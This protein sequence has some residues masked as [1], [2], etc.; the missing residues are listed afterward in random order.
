MSLYSFSHCRTF[1][2]I[3]TCTYM[4]YKLYFRII[5]SKFKGGCQSC[6]QQLVVW[7]RDYVCASAIYTLLH[8]LACNIASYC[9]HGLHFHLPSACA[10]ENTTPTH[11]ICTSVMNNLLTI[12][13]T[14]SCLF[15]H[16][17][18]SSSPSKPTASN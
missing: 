16:K 7:E 17:V 6:P 5:A 12:T 11:A 2:D 10:C 18:M 14:A 3:Y 15:T 1:P 9:T 13:T 8:E 4:T